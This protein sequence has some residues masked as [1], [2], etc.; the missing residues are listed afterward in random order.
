VGCLCNQRL[1]ALLNSDREIDWSIAQCLY[2]PTCSW[3]SLRRL[4]YRR[5]FCVFWMKRDNAPVKA[6]SYSHIVNR[7]VWSGAVLSG[8]AMSAPPIDSSEA[9]STVG[10]SNAELKTKSTRPVTSPWSIAETMSLRSTGTA[11][12]VE[13]NWRYAD[14]LSGKIPFGKAS[15]MIRNTCM[16]HSLNVLPTLNTQHWTRVTRCDS[17]ILSVSVWRRQ[18]NYSGHNDG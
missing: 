6:Q 15:I 10:L 5:R 3:S 4:V 13:W 14:C 8:L 12:S 16:V 17:C 2:S 18:L 11:Y 7:A 9:W 1:G